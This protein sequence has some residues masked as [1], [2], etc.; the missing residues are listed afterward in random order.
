VNLEDLGNVGEFIGGLA[1]FVTLV[2]LAIQIR[3]NTRMLRASAEQT[4]RSDSTAVIGLSA[5]SPENASVYHRG[6][7]DP[8]TLS[9]EERTHFYLILSANFYHLN[10]GYA[11]HRSGTQSDDTWMSQWQGLQFF[12]TQPGVQVWWEHQGKHLISP[13]SDFWQVVDAE[14]QKSNEPAA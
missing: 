8:D 7:A 9:P 11:G 12:A 6:L 10:Q 3:Q 13:G 5:M 4:T 14:F 1:V 2:Y